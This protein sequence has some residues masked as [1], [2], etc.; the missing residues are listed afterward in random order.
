MLVNHLHAKSIVVREG[1]MQALT[2]DTQKLISHSQR[3]LLKENVPGY[4]QRYC[5]D[6]Y[7]SRNN[8]LLGANN[9][10]YWQMEKRKDFSLYIF[11]T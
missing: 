1:D 11:E 3:T 6:T 10:F 8:I 2:L 7:L 9:Y 4:V 5:Q